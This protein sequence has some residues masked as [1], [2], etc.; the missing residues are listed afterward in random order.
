[1]GNATISLGERG[2]A[3][4]DLKMP[5]SFEVLWYQE[6][7]FYTSYT[8]SRSGNVDMGGLPCLIMKA[9]SLTETR[10]L[11]RQDTELTF[12]Y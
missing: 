12:N 11:R 5:S 1:V 3:A 8:A 9:Q 7:M 10:V 2:S 4:C 6:N